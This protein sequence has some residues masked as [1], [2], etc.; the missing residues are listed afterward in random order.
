MSIFAIMD[1]VHVE[2]LLLLR[3]VCQI[4]DQNDDVI[5]AKMKKKEAE[6]LEK[7]KAKAKEEDEEDSAL[8]KLSLSNSMPSEPIPP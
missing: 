2:S 6:K 4:Q 5:R 8:V 7:E 3:F 1:D